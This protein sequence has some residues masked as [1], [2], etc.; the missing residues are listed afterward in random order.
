MSSHPSFFRR[1]CKF[2]IRFT[3][4]SVAG[5]RACEKN[6]FR[7]NENFSFLEK[8]RADLHACILVSSHDRRRLA[9]LAAT[10]I[11]TSIITLNLRFTFDFRMN[12]CSTPV[13]DDE[14]KIYE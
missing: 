9:Y 1:N 2:S 7:S 4:L 8:F 3:T 6:P 10:C 12:D 14:T 11:C 5:I 13:D